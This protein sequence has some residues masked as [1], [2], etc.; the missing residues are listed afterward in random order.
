M[1]VPVLLGLLLGVATGIVWCM[2]FLVSVKAMLPFAF[3]SVMLLFVE[4]A[5]HRAH[6]GGEREGYCISPTC[7]SV[8]R[9]SKIILISAAVFIAVALLIFAA[10]LSMS[11]AVKTV[12]AFAGSISFWLTLCSFLAMLLSIF[13]YR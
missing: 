10:S 7:F 13:Y 6:C 5:V 8:L 12:L 4:T 9:F 11:F 2:G 1:W 3:A